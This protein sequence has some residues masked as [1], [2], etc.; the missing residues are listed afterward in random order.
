LFYRLNVVPI[1]LPA[2]RERPDDIDALARHF[3]ALAATEG[4]PRR[5]LTPDASQ[6]LSRQPWR[7]NVR[8]LRNFIY[9]LALLAREDLVDAMTLEPLLAQS[10]RADEPHD[11][12]ANL[13]S[14]VTNW[15]RRT[16]PAQGAC[17]VRAAA[18]RRSARL[19]QRQPTPRGADAG[20]KP[21]HLAQAPG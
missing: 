15:L 13:D 21:Q 4:L 12:A 20:D 10:A 16:S 5:Q 9:R 19:D 17:C 11:N 7:G 1:H 3:L 2:L 14:A 6:L 18:V 8:E